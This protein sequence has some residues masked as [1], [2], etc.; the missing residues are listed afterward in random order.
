M[1]PP[2][3]VL[4]EALSRADVRR[5]DAELGAIDSHVQ[6]AAHAAVSSLFHGG[7][8]DRESAS[9][10]DLTSAWPH[11]GELASALSWR[12]LRAAGSA[13]PEEP[14]AL[15]ATCTLTEVE[16]SNRR[17]ASGGLVCSDAIVLRLC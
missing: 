1:S 4:V 3:Q 5:G 11:N 17:V 8:E 9:I 10:M 13:W 16:Q 7:R 12:S 6:S 15:A 14:G 2:M